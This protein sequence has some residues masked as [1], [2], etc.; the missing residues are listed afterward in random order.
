MDND[1]NKDAK[2]GLIKELNTFFWM[3]TE[4]KIIFRLVPESEVENIKND[5]YHILYDVVLDFYEKNKIFETNLDQD[6]LSYLDEITENELDIFRYN[7]SDMI[8]YTEERLF[9]DERYTECAEFKC[10]FDNI[11]RCFRF[12]MV[13]VDSRKKEKINEEIANTQ[14][15][16]DNLKKVEILS[17]DIKRSYDELEHNTSQLYKVIENI[18]KTANNILPM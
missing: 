1:K 5:Y 6:V 10:L 7:I 9:C 4:D 14:K 11:I 2:L 16:R 15:L 3:L 17:D 18:E 12:T 13:F 8:K